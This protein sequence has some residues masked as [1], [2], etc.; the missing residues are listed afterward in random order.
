[1]ANTRQKWHP[2]HQLLPS[3]QFK[4]P[5]RPTFQGVPWVEKLMQPTD[6]Q[7]ATCP[8]HQLSRGG[9]SGAW[10]RP[11]LVWAVPSS[12]PTRPCICC[13]LCGWL[14]GL[15]C[16][17]VWCLTVH[18]W[19]MGFPESPMHN[20][21]RA[22]RLARFQRRR[23]NSQVTWGKLCEQGSSISEVLKLG[24]LRVIRACKLTRTHIRTSV[25]QHITHKH[26][27]TVT[28]ANT[29]QAWRSQAYTWAVWSSTQTI[30][31]LGPSRSQPQHAVWNTA[32][33]GNATAEQAP[34]RHNP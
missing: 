6:E 7:H 17:I 21:A 26:I 2:K 9:L 18:T 16:L 32:R 29:L 31:H 10:I 3:Q 8:P 20:W 34:R 33:A 13:E 14:V 4:V 15:L 19:L 24:H 27:H 1:M 11:F 28:L 25:V 23:A 5:T 30:C 12:I 22:I